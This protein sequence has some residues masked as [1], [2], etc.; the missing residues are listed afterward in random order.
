MTITIVLFFV[1][2]VLAGNGRMTIHNLRDLSTQF[3]LSER[4]GG[5]I[6]SPS[7]ISAELRRRVSYE[8]GK[9][10][11]KWDQGNHCFVLKFPTNQETVSIKPIVMHRNIIKEHI[12]SSM[13]EKSLH[14]LLLGYDGFKK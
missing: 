11:F 4:H 8:I 1:S 2:Q 10:K 14:D 12:L 5:I 3:M 9:T 7:D 6:Y 13:S